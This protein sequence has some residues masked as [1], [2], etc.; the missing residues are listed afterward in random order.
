[1]K[2]SEYKRLCVQIPDVIKVIRANVIDEYD[3]LIGDLNHQ[4]EG[5]KADRDSI[6]DECIRAIDSESVISNPRARK[7][8]VEAINAIKG[9]D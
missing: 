7:N 3:Q 1:M 8:A 6:R 2:K 5:F 9:D 4:I